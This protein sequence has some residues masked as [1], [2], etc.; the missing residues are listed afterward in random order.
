VLI[1]SV[2]QLCCCSVSQSCLTLCDPMDCSTPGLL[3]P[4][5]LPEFAQVQFH[6]IDDAI[7]PSHPLMPSSSALSLS[8]YQGLFQWV[9]CSHQ[10]TKI[11]ELQLQDQSFQWIFRIKAPKIDWFDLLAVKG[12]FR[13]LLQHHRLRHQ[14]FG[15]LPSLQ[16]SSH[17]HT[18]PL[19]EPQFAFST[20]CLMRLHQIYQI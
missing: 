6:C 20:Y 10:M 12:T 9:I 4:H 17:N 13:S 2:I 19:V 18:W 16:S 5:Y 3:V 11:Q 1:S 7:Q 14:F 15:I 8:Q